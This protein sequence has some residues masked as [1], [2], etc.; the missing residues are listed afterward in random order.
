MWFLGVAVATK[1]GRDDSVRLCKHGDLVAPGI[2]KLREAV[3]QNHRRPLPGGHV[4]LIQA[5]SRQAVMGDIDGIHTYSL[6]FLL[7]PANAAD[8]TVTFQPTPTRSSKVQPESQPIC[9][10]T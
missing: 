10:T 2:P 5:V 1:I 7:Q 8:P 9:G 6:K 4:V 3:Q